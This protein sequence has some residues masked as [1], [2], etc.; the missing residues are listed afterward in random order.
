MDTELSP[1]PGTLR[2]IFHVCL[3]TGLHC[4]TAH[5][6]FI[7]INNATYSRRTNSSLMR[8]DPPR[9]QR[10]VARTNTL[11]SVLRQRFILFSGRVFLGVFTTTAD[12]S[13]GMLWLL[14]QGSQCF[15][16]S[17]L[18]FWLKSWSR[19]RRMSLGVEELPIKWSMCVCMVC[20]RVWY[21]CVRGV[22][23]G[24]VCLCVPAC[25]GA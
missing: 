20:A 7:V 24:L 23:C 4:Y 22:R 8:R 3:L 5:M 11:L 9:F 12:S 6:V 18:P 21:V 1:S 13:E 2:V 10:L 14:A 15:P 25:V 16:P 19:S 17:L